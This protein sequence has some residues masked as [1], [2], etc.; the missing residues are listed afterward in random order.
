MERTHAV[1]TAI[2]D[3]PF[4]LVTKE[5]VCGMDLKYVYVRN[6]SQRYVDRKMLKLFSCDQG[7]LR[8][9]HSVRP[10]VRPSV[11]PFSL[12]SHHRIIMKFSGV[13]TNDKSELHTKDQGQRSKVKVT[14]VKT[15]LNRFRTVTP[16]W[17]YIWW[18][19]DAQSLMLP[20]K[21]ALLFIKVICQICQGH[22][23]KKIVDFDPNWAFPDCNSSLNSPMAAKW[24]TK[25]EVA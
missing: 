23:N 3:A 5:G 7:A 13:I 15:Q 8:M 2:C 24:C 11:T 14:E 19:N 25:L 1:M 10:S 9:V 16:V 18:C 4:N 20:G 21:G 12:C 6:D 22:T 17:I